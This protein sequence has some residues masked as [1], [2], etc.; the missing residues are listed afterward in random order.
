MN[1]T[2]LRGLPAALLLLLF[3]AAGWAG[4]ET[5]AADRAAIALAAQIRAGAETLTRAAAVA[6]ALGGAAVTLSLATLAALFLLYRRRPVHALLLAAAVLAER[7]LVDWLK[8]FTG[9]QRPPGGELAV[10]SLAFPS[11]HAANSMTAFLL[12]AMLAVPARHRR[13]AV[14]AAVASSLVIGL[15]RILLGV[16]WPSD[17]AAGWALGL[18]MASGAVA[19]AR[20]LDPRGLEPQ[21]DIVGGHGHPV[22]KDEAP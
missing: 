6:T 15:T 16:H 10:E 1:F 17:V 2:L 9:R 20:R 19:A 14:T 18:V 21:H 7:Q 5:L 11:G 22:G 12:V 3:L 8:I 13:A 4:G